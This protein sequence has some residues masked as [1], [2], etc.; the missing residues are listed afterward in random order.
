[1]RGRA[2]VP[3]KRGGDYEERGGEY[4]E[5]GGA[6]NKPLFQGLAGI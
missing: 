2:Y 4:E 6:T 5:M 1:M 3:E